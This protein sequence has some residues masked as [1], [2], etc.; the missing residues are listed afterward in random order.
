MKKGPVS[1][2][3]TKITLIVS[4]K[5]SFSFFKMFSSLPSI[6]KFSK[7]LSLKNC[8]KNS[9]GIFFLH[10]I[11][12]LLECTCR[13]KEKKHIQSQFSYSMVA[14]NRQLH[15]L[16]AKLVLPQKLEWFNSLSFALFYVLIVSEI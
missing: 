4:I 7:S 10:R 14:L 1:S 9:K 15:H 16:M 2:I 13:C 3:F 6:K 5:R 11:L 12:L 8:K